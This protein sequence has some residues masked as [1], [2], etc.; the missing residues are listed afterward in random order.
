MCE[1]ES[2]GDIAPM[3]CVVRIISSQVQLQPFS[4]L[5]IQ[6]RLLYR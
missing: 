3:H 2:D 5:Q 1:P 4:G 6:Q